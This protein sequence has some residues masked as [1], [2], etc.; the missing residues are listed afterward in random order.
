[1][2]SPAEA[3]NLLR[4]PQTDTVSFTHAIAE[5]SGSALKHNFQTLRKLA[6]P[7][8][9]IPMVKANAY[10]HD[11]LWV[12]QKLQNEAGLDGFG[13]AT[14]EEGICLREN[15][16]KN[17]PPK[18]LVFSGSIPWKE[19][20][21]WLCEKHQLVPVLSSWESW[22]RFYE[23]NWP[24]R[25]P[26]EI[27]F[28]TGMNRLGLPLDQLP[29]LLQQLRSLESHSLP[30][31]ISSHL[32]NAENP[33]HAQSKEQLKNFKFLA[34]AFK[35][36]FP[37]IP[38]HLGNSAA[39]L[40]ASAWQLKNNTHRVRP[41]LALYG[42]LPWQK[43]ASKKG[44]RPELATQLQP[45]MTLKVQVLAVQPLK[46]GSRVGYGG[47]YK[48]PQPQLLA[49]L[50]AGYADGLHRLLSNQGSVWLQ[51]RKEKFLGRISMDLSAVRCTSETKEGDWAE[52][53]GKNHSVWENAQAAKTI[54]YELFTALSDRIK[55][56][57]A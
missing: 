26:Y 18:I 11:M 31:G 49:I 15:L 39:L 32:A 40:K 53:F 14:L 44:T 37:E 29:Q 10:G 3:K 52:V 8:S 54:P 41:G 47:T 24:T 45:V 28:N 36:Q 33:S 42:I 34:A 51:G 48:T 35:N 12:G 2:L 1:M 56:H 22:L 5:L 38:L 13:V 7:L 23:Q 43:T 9:L 55:R 17:A 25:L 19:E 21:G 16:K 30:S 50:G 4:L 27:K 57:Y 20:M 46:R 6:E